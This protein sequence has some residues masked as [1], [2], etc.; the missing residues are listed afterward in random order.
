MQQLS[1]ITFFIPSF[2]HRRC[3]IDFSN[4]FED[5]RRILRFSQDIFDT[6]SIEHEI[7]LFVKNQN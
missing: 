6:L 1:P 4:M 2:P 5:Q 3:V 7:L